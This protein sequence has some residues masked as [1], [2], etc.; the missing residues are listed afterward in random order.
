MSQLGM[1]IIAIGLSSYNIALFHLVNH[2]FYKGLLFLGA[3][4]VIHAVYDNQDFRKYGGLRPFLPLTYSV[5][6]IASLSLVAFPFMTGFYSKDFILESSYGQFYFNSI[7]VYFMATIGAMFTTLYSV[8]VLYLTFLINPNGPMSNYKSSSTKN[9]A[10]EGDIFMSLPLI[11][12]A[13]F[14]I[15]F[16]YIGKD[17]FIGLG[18]GFFA[19]NSI[20][21]HPVREIMLNTEFA[22]PTLFKLLPLLFT[23]SLS[24]IAIVISEFMPKIII[25]FKLSRIGYNIFSFFSQRFFIELLYNKYITDLILKLG[26]QTTKVLDKGSVELLGPFGLE[27][28]LLLLSRS[29]STLNTGVITSYALYILVGLIVY[30]LIPYFYLFDNSLLLLVLLS[31]I[32]VNNNII[33]LTTQ[34]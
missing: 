20:F 6:L 8:K 28:G 9:P 3:G 25:D 29:I 26:G 1:M 4:A 14:S 13:I 11:V 19:D 32:T 30:T 22:V 23:I 27:K 33:N 2:A 7:L 16:G 5:M 17:I 12:L 31:L 34:S 10:H 15:F 21:I 24:A 18:S